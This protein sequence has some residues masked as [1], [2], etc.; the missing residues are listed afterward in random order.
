MGGCPDSARRQEL[1]DQIF[2]YKSVIRC[3]IWYIM[4][5]TYTYVLRYIL[6]SPCLHFR[7]EHFDT[8]THRRSHVSACVIFVFVSG[9]FLSRNNRSTIPNGRPPLCHTT[10]SSTKRSPRGRV[11]GRRTCLDALSGTAKHSD[12]LP[13]FV[14]GE[15]ASEDGPLTH[16]QQRQQH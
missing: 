5:A 16:C 8:R 7:H 2:R 14:D 3:Y 4:Y 10:L 13:P 11:R 15:I 9:T 6:C 1:R 12:C